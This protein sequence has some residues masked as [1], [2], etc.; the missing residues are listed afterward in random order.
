MIHHIVVQERE[1][2]KNLERQ[3]CRKGLFYRIA[4]DQSAVDNTLRGGESEGRTQPFATRGKGIFNRLV[5]SAGLFLPVEG[6]YLFVNVDHNFQY[7][8]KSRKTVSLCLKAASF[9]L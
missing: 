1:I 5:Q 4:V 3:R 9:L 8:V 6:C 7:K 2:M